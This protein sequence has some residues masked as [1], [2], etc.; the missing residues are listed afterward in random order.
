MLLN[1]LKGILSEKDRQVEF[2][3][4]KKQLELI[5]KLLQEAEKLEQFEN[6]KKQIYEPKQEN[7][8]IK[9]QQNQSEN[10]VSNS[11]KEDHQD[12]RN[13]FESQIRLYGLH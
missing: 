2:D 1:F 8:N 7:F 11:K 4:Q 9:C 5:F 3:C 12:I 6:V 10:S 13:L